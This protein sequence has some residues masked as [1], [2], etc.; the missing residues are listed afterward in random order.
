MA[1]FSGTEFITH[2]AVGWL[3]RVYPNMGIFGP[4][5]VGNNTFFGLNYTI[6]PGATIGSNRVINAGSAVRGVIPDDSVVM[7]NPAK[8]IMKTSLLRLIRVN[9]KR[10]IETYSF[11]S[12]QRKRA[13][14]KYFGMECFEE[15]VKPLA[16]PDRTERLPG[17]GILGL[18]RCA[19]PGR[20]PAGARHHRFDGPG[21]ARDP[22]RRTLRVPDLRAGSRPREFL[23]A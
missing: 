10:R 22:S 15:Q 5:R 11:N 19:P 8:V 17:A 23:D 12:E 20:E 4:I 6:Q 2:D 16:H 7:G 21:Q 3:F 9:S 1:I 13:M 18:A 14:F